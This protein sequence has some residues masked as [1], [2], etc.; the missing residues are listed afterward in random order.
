MSYSQ[1]MGT[2]LVTLVDLIPCAVKSQERYNKQASML[3][4]NTILQ[5]QI[6]EFRNMLL[7]I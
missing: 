2:Y 6:L 4:T 3:L 5:P 1:Y 7:P